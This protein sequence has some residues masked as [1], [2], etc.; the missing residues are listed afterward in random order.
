[1][2]A[3]PLIAMN[4]P[5][6]CNKAQ[7]T[8]H[9]GPAQ[10]L[11]RAM[12]EGSVGAQL[13]NAYV[14]TRSE[15]SNGAS[16]SAEAAAIE[17]RGKAGWRTFPGRVDGGRLFERAASTHEI[18]NVVVNV[19]VPNGDVAP[20]N[21]Y[22]GPKAFDVAPRNIQTLQDDGPIR[23]VDVE[24]APCILSVQDRLSR[25]ER[26]DREALANEGNFRYRG[27][28]SAIPSVRAISEDELI[29]GARV[30]HRPLQCTHARLHEM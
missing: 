14:L 28:Y 11:Q 6:P 30:A 4:M 22:A 1:M 21:V 17:S 23:D 7:P 9:Q 16:P 20:G 24:D 26:T 19:T 2:T 25:I 29:A 3:S 13:R 18:R 12:D 8:D 15:C 5:A 10:Q 27:P